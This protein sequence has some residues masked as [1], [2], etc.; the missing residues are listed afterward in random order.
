MKTLTL[1][2]LI[3]VLGFTSNAQQLTTDQLSY[4]RVRE[5]KSDYHETLKKAFEK[6]NV[7][8]PP[9]EIYISSYKFDMEMEL[10]AKGNSG[11]DFK[12]IK[13]YEICQVSGALGPKREQGDLQIPEG[14]YQLEY[15]NPN[16]AYHLSMKINYPNKAD[17]LLGTQGNL[18]G[19]IFIHG[20][21]VT[22]GC[23]PIQ[24]EPIKELY[25]LSVL[26]KSNGGKIP[27]H[28]FPFRMNDASMS[29]FKK[30]PHLG[31]DEWNLWYQL[32]PIYNYFQVN[33]QL[34]SI[35]I[36]SKGEYYISKEN[37]A[38]NG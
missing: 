10:W 27:I 32:Q 38:S 37:H 15:F 16:S 26:T 11:E 17:Q 23:L 25:W 14:V 13:T 35:K 8:F 28:I 34:P 2:I 3:L 29:F 9:A 31:K 19:D 22:I 1:L 18:G 7:Q 12:L 36:N 4:P 24:D 21:C 6:K 5:A 20:D 33:K 30:V